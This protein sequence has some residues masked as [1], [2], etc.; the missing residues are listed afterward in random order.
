MKLHIRIAILYPEWKTNK[1]AH[2]FDIVFLRIRQYFVAYSGHVM[3]HKYF[4]LVSSLNKSIF[5]L[6]THVFKYT[7]QTPALISDIYIYTCA[8]AGVRK[9]A[10]LFAQCVSLF[11][12]P[13]FPAV[14]ENAQLKLMRI[15]ILL[16]TECL[17]ARCVTVPPT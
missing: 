14:Q 9:R 10:R 6:P 1:Q 16:L 5:V 7:A 11:L 12:T 15:L 8:C 17:R 2:M 13:S 4:A 3:E